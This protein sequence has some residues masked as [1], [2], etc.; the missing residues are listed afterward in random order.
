MTKMECHGRAA[1]EV[2]AEARGGR[3]EPPQAGDLL[4]GQHLG[5]DHDADLPSHMR[6]SAF[7]SQ[8]FTLS[9][10]KPITVSQ[11]RS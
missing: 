6:R 8:A 3:C 7:A 9:A 2:K 4:V 1:S 5:V 10:G 11:N